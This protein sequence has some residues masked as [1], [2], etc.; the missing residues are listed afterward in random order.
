MLEYVIVARHGLCSGFPNKYLNPKGKIQTRNLASALK[1]LLKGLP[2]LLFASFA[3]WVMESA[4]IFGAEY[5]ISP[6]EFPAL[7]AMP[8]YLDTQKVLQ[9]IASKMDSS[10]AI[11][12]FTHQECASSL[13]EMCL[14]TFLQKTHPLNPLW[15]SEAYI[16]SL[17]KSRL[18][19]YAT[20]P[21]EN[22]IKIPLS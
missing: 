5:G 19:K 7:F 14:I 11:V 17:S 21:K 10:D 9:L 3:N 16:I 2:L 4:E 22:L 13:A 8:P 18:L 15:E 6:Q 12:L 1:P 20:V